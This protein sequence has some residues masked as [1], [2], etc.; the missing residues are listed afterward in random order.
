MGWIIK[1][2][3]MGE[4]YLNASPNGEGFSFFLSNGVYNLNVY[5]INVRVNEIYFSIVYS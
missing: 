2:Y 3:L 5:N 1:L 4:D